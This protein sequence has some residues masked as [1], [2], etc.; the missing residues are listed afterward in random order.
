MSAPHSMT[1]AAG[2]GAPLDPLRFPLHGQRLIEASAGTGKTFTIAAL[3]V[4]LVLGHGGADAFARA[5]APPEI[6]VVT[7]TEAATK[8][9]RERIRARLAEAAAAFL[10]APQGEG[11]QGEGPTA[12]DDD[13]LARLRADHAPEHWPACAR[14]LQLAAEW[15][16]EAAVSTIHGWCKRMLREHAFASGSLFT[17]TLEA[18]QGELLA[19]AVRDYWRT[20][21]VPL[22]AAQAAEVAHWWSGPQA[23][24][25]ALERLV[26]HAAALEASAPRS[27]P[28]ALLGQAAAERERRLAALKAPW[29]GWADEL[30]ALLERAVAGA[31]VNGQKLR[32][33][34]YLPWLDKLR[35]WAGDP[36][37]VHLELG[38]GWTR[39]TPAGLADAW[40]ADKGAPPSHPALEAVAALPAAL[41][42]LPD[43]FGDLLRHAACWVA[44]RFAAEQQRRAQMG[45]DDLLTRLD[46]ALQGDNGAGLAERIRSTFPV[47]LIDEFQDTDPVQ[48]RIFDAVYGVTRAGADPHSRAGMP[49]ALVLIGDPKQAIYA[50]RGADIFTYLAARRA[51]AGRRYTLGRNFRSTAPMVAAVNRCFGFAEARSAGA[52]AFLFRPPGASPDDNPLPFIP[53]AAQGRKETLEID[54][55]PVAALT[56]WWL[57]AREDGKSL[58]KGA[59]REQ[60]AAAC[61]SAM[62]RLLNRGRAGAA[63]FVAGTGFAALRPR[64]LAVLVHTRDEADAIRAALAVRGVRSVYLSDRDSVFDSARAE[65]L[66]HWLAACAEPDDARL[67]RAALAT[68]TLGLDWA[69]LDGL[70]RDERAWEARVLQFRGYRELWRRQGVLPMLRRL[71]HDFDVPARLLGAAAVNGGERALTDLLHLAELLQQASAVL[72]GEH[73]LIRHLARQRQPGARTGSGDEGRQIRLES[74]ADLVQVVTVHKSK[75]LEYPLV[76]LPF[77]CSWRRVGAADRPLTVHD[78]GGRAQL[79]LCADEDTL[80]RADRERLGEDLRKLYV[81]LTRARHATWVGLAPLDELEHSA[82]GYLLAGGAPIAPAA[83]EAHLRA[84]KGEADC[85]AVAPAPE[86]TAE[87]YAAPGADAVPGPARRPRRSVREH[88]WIASYSALK[89]GGHGD[90]LPPAVADTVADAIADAVAEAEARGVRPPAAPDSAAEATFHETLHAT[91]LLAA[92]P[93]SVPAQGAG[94]HAFPRG[95]EAGTFLHELLEWAAE[96]GFASLAADPGGLRDTVARRC[97]M[98]GW[99]AWIGPLTAWLEHFLAAELA[100]PAAPGRAA[101]RLRLAGLGAVVAEM[102]FW[103]T[104]DTLDTRVLDRLVCAHTLD[105]AARPALL[106]DTLGGMLKGFIDL[107]FEH[108]GRFYVADYKSNWLGADDGAYTAAAMRAAVLAQRYELQYTLYLLALHR[109][110]QARLPGYD[111]DRHVGGALYLFLR[112]SR[113]PGA[114]VH[115]ERPPKAL[116]ETLDRLFAGTGAVGG[117]GAVAARLAEGSE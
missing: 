81:A 40:K 82:F 99:E 117:G 14:K 17:Q 98:R 4:R 64:D 73:A 66:Q 95:A 69:A 37:A 65:E 75:G 28:A 56:A 106:P 85:I 43:A 12:V 6:L 71:L 11:A 83:L 39:L 27:A 34:Y 97:R 111:Y 60:M 20:F 29:P 109:L 78:A 93:H 49:S 108:E 104:V 115:F 100:L 90:G 86:P 76:F 51:C 110:L 48:F 79:L 84:L 105:A 107:L 42:A 47:A 35:A 32:A 24:Q 112:G 77:A 67:L 36:G 50:F 92:P 9:L 113:A 7:F 87:R 72:D 3:Y 41:A 18:D 1:P 45:F 91:P 5:L 8:E 53:A 94:L 55:R 80:A 25:Q 2:G 13:F 44:A 31:C 57:A 23:L 102:E 19:E 26:G 116:I 101:T 30:Q 74:D 103:L 46:R 21:I 15:M 38:T 61:A 88:W 96:R 10:P 59:Y 62:V 63:G 33:Q 16:D 58:P 114:G 68:A 22:D 52:G 70:D 89:T 54:G